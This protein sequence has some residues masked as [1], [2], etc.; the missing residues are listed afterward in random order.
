MKQ[1]ES[2]VVRTSSSCGQHTSIYLRLFSD[3]ASRKA[4]TINSCMMVFN[5]ASGVVVINGFLGPI[6]DRV[7]ATKWSG[8]ASA[9]AISL[10]RLVSTVIGS[11]LVERRGRKP[12]LMWSAGLAAFSYLLIGLYFQLQESRYEFVALLSPAPFV[13]IVLFTLADSFGLEP[14]PF[15]YMSEFFPHH[16]KNLGVPVC[17]A[18]GFLVG[19]LIALVFPYFMD[20]L[21]MQWCFWLFGTICVT[22]TI[23]TKYVVPDTDGKTLEEIQRLMEQ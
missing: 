3:R 12:L 9:I 1:I 10:V 8:N 7:T 18:I 5:L 22:C 20:Y 15:A 6:L 16:V 19:G 23:F 11:F 2:V 17:T 4:F 14:V 21:G 13:C